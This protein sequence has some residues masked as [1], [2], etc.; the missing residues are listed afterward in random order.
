MDDTVFPF[1]CDEYILNNI[2]YVKFTDA[3]KGRYGFS[4]YNHGAYILFIGET[5]FLIIKHDDNNYEYCYDYDVANSLALVVNQNNTTSV[6]K[7]V[8]YLIRDVWFKNKKYFFILK[9]TTS[10]INDVNRTI[11]SILDFLINNDIV[12]IMRHSHPLRQRSI[13]VCSIANTHIYLT[14]AQQNI[15]C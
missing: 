8:K 1:I 13:Y 6:V 9:H 12:T 5:K 2:K 10:V 7:Y 14:N 11:H 15:S 3:N 4:Q